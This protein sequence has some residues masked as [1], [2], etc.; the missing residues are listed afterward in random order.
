MATV[1]RAG[2]PATV[3]PSLAT[4]LLQLLLLPL[5]GPLPS[6]PHPRSAF[7]SLGLAPAVAAIPVALGY[8]QQPLS[9]KVSRAPGG[10][11]RKGGRDASFPVFKTGVFGQEGQLW[12]GPAPVLSQVMEPQ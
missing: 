7:P 5:P 1:G 3:P 2:G 8:P 9:G 11:G 6:S 12:I 10:E 4:H